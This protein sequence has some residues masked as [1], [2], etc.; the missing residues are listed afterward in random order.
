VSY[1]P[2]WDEWVPLDL[3]LDERISGFLRYVKS[4]VMGGY[5]LTD[6]MIGLFA[7]VG[8]PGLNLAYCNGYELKQTNAVLAALADASTN[9]VYLHFTKTV[10]PGGGYSAITLDIT[11][12]QTGIDPGDAIKLGEVDTAAGVITAIREENNKYRI[13]TAQLDEDIDG[14]QYKIERLSLQRGVAF[15]TNPPPV[16]SELFWRTDLGQLYVFDGLVW[17]PLT[18]GAPPGAVIFTAGAP[19]LPGEV[20]YISAPNTVLQANATAMATAEVVGAS[21]GIVPPLTPGS[22]LT[23]HG[24]TGTVFVEN[25]GPLIPVAGQKVWL[26]KTVPGSVTNIPPANPCARKV[27]GVITDP[28][29]YAFPG[30][31]YVT[32]AWGP[33]PTIWIP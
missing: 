26:S 20:A 27:L 33:E 29:M 10:D 9:Y 4:F 12:N 22:F 1:D 11:V 2:N 5:Q 17:Q 6:P 19:F 14:N 32:V 16:Q 31:P 28:T 25:A 15:P 24:Q 7:A 23:W 3:I 30:N 18:A 21:L 8:Q 13:H